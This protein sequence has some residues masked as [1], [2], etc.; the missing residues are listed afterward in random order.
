VGLSLLYAHHAARILTARCVASAWCVEPWATRI[1]RDRWACSHAPTHDNAAADHDARMTELDLRYPLRPVPAPSRRPWAGGRLGDG[2]IGEL[3]LAGPDSPIPGG[4]GDGNLSLDQLAMR[5]GAS[6]VG[7]RP[8]ASLG[9]RFPLLIK[10]IDAAQPLSLQ[11]HP[12]DEM[13]IALHGEGSLGKTEAWVVLDADPGATLITGPR[14]SLAEADLRATIAAG[15]LGRDECEVNDG[16]PGDAWLIPPGTIHSIGAGL[17]VY[18]I[19]QPSDLT[20]RISDWGRPATS[21]RPLHISE[22]LGALMPGAHALRSG[23]GFTLDDGALAV[24][25]FRLEIIGGSGV[26]RHPGGRSLEVV[27]AVRGTVTLAGDDW[28]ID[29]SPYETIVIPAMVAS[30]VVALDGQALAFVG[31]VP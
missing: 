3:W 1:L 9:P 11:L 10:I 20:Y 30:Y 14:E 12:S 27:T 22:S 28:S 13:A 7:D 6:L 18:E 15:S 31:S 19:E 5:H 4:A 17:L 29:L 21:G 16:R 23:T 26:S 2:G 24:P 25:E 8:L